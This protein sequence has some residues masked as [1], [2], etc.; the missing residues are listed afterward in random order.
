[1]IEGSSMLRQCVDNFLRLCLSL[2]ALPELTQMVIGHRYR[3]SGHDRSDFDHATPITDVYL[4]VHTDKVWCQSDG[5]T[6]AR[7]DLPRGRTTLAALH[8][9]LAAIVGRAVGVTIRVCA[10]TRAI[11]MTP[12]ISMATT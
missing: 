8:R 4:A 9:N 5:A 12:T 7:P 10:A 2:T 11:Q 3:E 6:R 1:M